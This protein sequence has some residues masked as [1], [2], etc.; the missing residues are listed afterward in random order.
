MNR[1]R[2][3]G[4]L[5]TIHQS[6]NLQEKW[7]KRHSEG[8]KKEGHVPFWKDPGKK[9]EQ[10]LK[11]EHQPIGRNEIPKGTEAQKL[12]PGILRNWGGNTR[13]APNTSGWAKIFIAHDLS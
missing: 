3:N 2:T 1:S 13:Q 6:T 7:F 11:K 9:G 12:C 4:S 8:T 10:L 5:L